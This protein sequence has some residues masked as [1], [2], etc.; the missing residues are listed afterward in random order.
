ME[1][2]QV[3]ISNRFIVSD[4]LDEILNINSA[5]EVLQKISDLSKRKLR[6]SQAKA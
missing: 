2:Y 4:N 3:E 6:I 5:C 1:K